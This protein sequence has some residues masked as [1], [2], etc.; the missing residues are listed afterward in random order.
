MDRTLKV[1]IA[2]IISICLLLYVFGLVSES[3]QMYAL[4][5]IAAIMCKFLVD[6]R[7]DRVAMRVRM[8]IQSIMDD[9]TEQEIDQW[10]SDYKEMNYGFE[11]DASNTYIAAMI[12]KEK[13]DNLPSSILDGKKR[14]KYIVDDYEFDPDAIYADDVNMIPKSD[15]QILEESRSITPTKEQLDEI[16]KINRYSHDAF[17]YK[18]AAEDFAKR[19]HAKESSRKHA[20]E[21]KQ[22]AYQYLFVKFGI[23]SLAE[24][25]PTKQARC[26]AILRSILH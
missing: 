18:L 11:S 21:D 6:I 16:V 7:R 17:G 3:L 20:E 12:R 22:F 23:D 5:F 15:E 24:P 9:I 25:E 19:Y 2:V 10:R 26:R 14:T 8:G 13:I 1:V 4:F